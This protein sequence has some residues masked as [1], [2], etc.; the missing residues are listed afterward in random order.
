M[1]SSD[2]ESGSTVVDAA[3]TSD[4]A[5]NDPDA[6][7]PKPSDLASGFQKAFSKSG[8]GI[9]CSM[10]AAQMKSAGA[11]SLTF[12][13]ATVFVG[14]EQV[15]DNQNPV[16]ARFDNDTKTYCERH[17]QEPPDG[18]ALGVTWDGGPKAYVV[19]TIVGGGSAF[20]AKAK[21]QWLDRYGD[22]GGSSKVTFLGEVDAAAGTLTRGTFVIAKKQDGKT[23]TH[24]PSDA[25]IVRSDGT[26]EVHG[27]SA[28]QPMNPD[29]SI[30]S[31]TGY[32]FFTT[33]VFA[34]DLKTLTCSS[35]TNCTAKVPCPSS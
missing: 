13:T 6:A 25:A 31:C 26:I 23:N 27:D 11:P 22:G 1:D 10:S 16:F 24:T 7:P 3:S 34:S 14:F 21:G 15:G 32:P 17:E 29:R 20:D 19:Y 2:G 30:M 4:G 28:F 33:Y 5:T 12:G 35:S 9:N 8:V 18:R